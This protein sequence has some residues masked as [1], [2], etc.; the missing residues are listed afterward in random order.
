MKNAFLL[1]GIL[2]IIQ[3]VFTVIYQVFRNKKEN[4]LITALQSSNFDELDRLLQARST[5]IFIGEYNREYLHLNALI[6][7]EKKKEINATFDKLIPMARNKKSKFD[8][9]N[10]AFSY[11]V[12]AEDRAHCDKLLKEIE[13][14][15]NKSFLDSCKMKYDIFILKKT[16]HITELEQNFDSLPLLKKL[17]NSVLLSEQYKNAGNPTKAKYYENLSKS[18]IEVK[19]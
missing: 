8:I 6:M 4:Q 3:I 12:F 17:N 16:N 2:I 10:K 1:I 14:L 11:Y 9:L 15:D 13:K 18:L 19:K 5:K 7:Q